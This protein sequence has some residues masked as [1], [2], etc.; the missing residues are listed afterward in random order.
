M[1]IEIYEEKVKNRRFEEQK[2]TKTS[3]KE[4]KELTEKEK[5]IAETAR[6]CCLYHEKL[7]PAGYFNSKA[8]G[9]SADL[10]PS[11]LRIKK[12]KLPESLQNVLNHRI[13]YLT[14]MSELNENSN[15]C[16]VLDKLEPQLGNPGFFNKNFNAILAGCE[17]IPEFKKLGR[18]DFKKAYS[19]VVTGIN[20][21]RAV[22]KINTN[23]Q[24]DA[25]IHLQ[26]RKLKISDKRVDDK[27][28]AKNLQAGLQIAARNLRLLEIQKS[29]KSA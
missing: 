28:A 14:L 17:K 12:D 22:T 27:D 23:W 10:L 19:I 18:D 6:L 21:L 9:I 2:Q 26:N 3:A 15:L 4:S 16:A 29:L 8:A 25:K 1:G 13:A 7:D 20:H 24:E 5:E 11:F